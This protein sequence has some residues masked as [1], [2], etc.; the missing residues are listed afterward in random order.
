MQQ[1]V[2]NTSMLSSS[3]TKLK[4]LQVHP[5]TIRSP[6]RATVNCCDRSDRYYTATISSSIVRGS[7][8]VPRQERKKVRGNPAKFATRAPGRHRNVCILDL[9]V[10]ADEEQIKG[11][12]R[13]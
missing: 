1:M 8:R 2:P 13:N 7:R 9:P 4:W 6:V 5:S 10:T 12:S 11:T 3:S